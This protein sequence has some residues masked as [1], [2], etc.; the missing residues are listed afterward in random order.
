MVTIK[1]VAKRAQV[2]VGTV[3]NALTNRR[4][5]TAST[6]KRIMDAIAE[7]GYQPNLLA[8]SL[9]D[10]R[11]HTLSIVTGRLEY[12][13]ASRTL[14]GIESA[15]RALGYSVMLHLVRRPGQVDLPAL[16]STL[17]SRRVDGV[18][19]AVPELASQA[20]LP[21]PIVFLFMPPQP[22][23]TVVS[24]DH[25]SG[26]LKAMQHLTEQG[27]KKIGL[28]NGPLTWWVARERQSGW[29][30][31]L[32]SAGLDA[33]ESRIVYGDWSAV[34]GE[35]CLT[36]LL[37]REPD[38]DA[39]LVSNDQ[40]ALGALRAAHRKGRRIPE[41]LAIVGF[42]NTPESSQYWPSLTTVDLR[43]SEIGRTAVEQ[44]IAMID[45]KLANKSEPEPVT[46]TLQPELIV[47]E[48]SA[49]ME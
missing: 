19:W 14:V 13:G 36:E 33:P 17:R 5:V 35:T 3:S 18:I 40:M 8:R 46:V 6:R 26:A 16:L 12:Y 2:S 37:D 1:D 42:D 44:L 28:V 11:S 23:R 10:R 4:Q 22:G 29:Q 25:R 20:E 45:A 30:D 39:V 21:L 47:R 31:A 7:L 34:S 49:K 41:D 38:L 24:M 9:V 27:R 32:Q 43:H 48:S 15:A